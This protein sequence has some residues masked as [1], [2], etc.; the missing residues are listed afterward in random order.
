E[1]RVPHQTGAAVDAQRLAAPG[2]EE[3]QA[4]VRVAED[5][6]EPVGAAVAGT[7]RDRDRRVVDDVD[8]PGRVALG[9]DVA[10]AVGVARGDEAERG[11]G[12]PFAVPGVQRY[13]LLGDRL[14]RGGADHLA[15]LLRA[16]DRGVLVGERH[17]APSGRRPEGAA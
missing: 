16:G 10:V 7:V 11:P 14:G 15:E 8:E 5:V 13:A 17:A 6:L 1:G 12:E 4:R 9:G 3:D 2:D